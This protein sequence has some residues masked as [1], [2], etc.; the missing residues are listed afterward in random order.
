MRNK[1]IKVSIF[2]CFSSIMLV[3]SAVNLYSQETKVRIIK[4]GAV[5]RL[6]PNPES[7]HI[8]NLPLGTIIEVEEVVGE[9]LK[10]KLPP[11]ER[12]FVITGYVHRSD[13]SFEI[14]PA[15][16]MPPEKIEEKVVEEKPRVAPVPPPKVIVK[17][18]EE[19]SPGIG[20]G[21][22]AGAALLDASNY[23]AGIAFGGRLCFSITK[24]IGLELKGLMFQSTVEQEQF[25]KLSDGKL[26]II[27]L[28]VSL[29]GRFP[30]GENFVPY[31]SAGLGYYLSSFEIDSEISDGWNAL[32]FDIEEKLESALAYH[33]GLGIDYFFSSKLALN[34]EVIYSLNE[35][36]G[37]WSIT[38]QVS[39][40][41]ASG[42][43]EE[44]GAS[45]FMIGIGLKYYF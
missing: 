13:V 17:E 45:N 3:F 37:F 30:V 22:F 25:D 35:S 26:S 12:G 41:Q 8:R 34:A 6:D 9:W 19:K 44:I 1:F 2:V 5:L 40:T 14:E 24:N 42:V 29:Q 11:D 38:D 21:V 28:Q 43:I 4:E 32:G 31:L 15:P 39:G 10:V 23:S 27:P 20:L 16:A 33:L 36:E 7:P 18:K